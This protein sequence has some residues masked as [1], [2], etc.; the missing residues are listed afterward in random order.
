MNEYKITY[1]V[2]GETYTTNRVE[3]TEATAKRAFPKDCKEMDTAAEVLGMELIR[4]DACAT[5]Q[6][7]R[8]TLA[9]IKKMVEEL[10]PQSYLATAF[11]ECFQDA[12]DNIDDDA[13][14]SMKGRWEST[15]RKAAELETELKKARGDFEGLAKKAELVDRDLRA[16]IVRT[17]EESSKAITALREQILSADELAAVSKLISEKVIDLGVE[18]SN[19]AERIVEAAGEPDSAMFQNAVKDHRAAKADLDSFT[20]LLSKVNTIRNATENH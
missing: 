6:Q 7:E 13:A 3:H 9:A 12:E 14:Y 5:K 11:A 19:A 20:P 15:E 16:S 1:S 17:K 18:V 4:D 10:G 8:D 2:N